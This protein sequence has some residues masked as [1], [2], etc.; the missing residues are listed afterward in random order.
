MANKYFEIV[1]KFKYLDTITNQN[2]MHDEFK[3]RLN[4][5]NASTIPFRIHC[6]PFDMGVQSRS[7]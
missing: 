1:A 3:S 7:T 6:L 2:C 5:G 4:S